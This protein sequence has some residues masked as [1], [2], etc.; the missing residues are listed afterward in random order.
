MK[1]VYKKRKISAVSSKAY[2]LYTKRRIL[3]PYKAAVNC[4]YKSDLRLFKPEERVR[5][6]SFR[7]L[8]RRYRRRLYFRGCRY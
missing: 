2:K 6:Q 1:R 4:V 7:A 3:Q 5:F 8:I